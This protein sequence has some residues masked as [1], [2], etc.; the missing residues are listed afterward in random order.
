MSLMGNSDDGVED[1]GVVYVFNYI[2]DDYVYVCVCVCVTGRIGREV[3]SRCREGF[4]MSTIGYD[5]VLS[6]AAARAA[7]IDL[8]SLDELF[9]RS[10]FITIHT[11]LVR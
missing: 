6:E 7:D 10:D 9:E 8:V 3:A 5:P 1:D 2:C 11:P 4:G